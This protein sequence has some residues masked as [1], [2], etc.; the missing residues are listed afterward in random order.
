MFF[1]GVLLLE[2][3]QQI[4]LSVRSDERLPI[5]S[6]TSC[7][8]HCTVQANT[9]KY[10]CVCDC[11]SALAHPRGEMSLGRKVNS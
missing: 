2:E 9:V 4:H 3:E 11:A 7:S 6:Q 8:S 5:V 1:Q 10:G